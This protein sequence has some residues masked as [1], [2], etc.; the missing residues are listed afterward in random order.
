MR[1][2][3]QFESTLP[4][5]YPKTVQPPMFSFVDMMDPGEKRWEINSAYGYD[6]QWYEATEYYGSFMLWGFEGKQLKRNVMLGQW[7]DRLRAM[8]KRRKF[9]GVEPFEG[10]DPEYVERER[11]KKQ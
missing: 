3:K 9:T 10:T 6:F 8:S 4:E 1:R 5:S 7:S 2:V 11:S